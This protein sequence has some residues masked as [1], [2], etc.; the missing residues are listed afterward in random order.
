MKNICITLICSLLIS[1]IASAGPR[2]GS[3]RSAGGK[4]RAGS[5]SIRSA[6]TRNMLSTELS[7]NS[8]TV[9][10]EKDTSTCEDIFY[11]CMDKKTT[12]VVMQNEIIY[13]DYNDMITDIY[14]GMSTPAFKCVYSPELKTI[15]SK[16]YYNRTLSA[17]IGGRSEKI[18]TK[19]IEYYNYLKQNA[20]DVA[21][22]KIPVNFIQN[23]VL[24]IAGIE[25]EPHNMNSEN[26]PDVSYKI[27]TIEPTKL[28]E[29][30]VEY[31][32][33]ESKNEELLG[34]QKL[35]KSLAEKWKEENPSLKK[36]CND[37]EVFLTEKMSKEKSAAEDFI[38]TLK[39]KLTSAIEEYNLKIEADEQ[40][41]ALEEAEAVRDKKNANNTNNTQKT[42]GTTAKGLIKS[43][44]GAGLRF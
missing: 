40:L 19:S 4:R 26:L 43:I 22:K 7:S 33:D 28:F 21:S 18:R 27:T 5:S 17:P 41:K 38:K 9:V 24:T 39:T 12:E 42:L 36:S 1:N 23:E 3:L 32:L 29:A 2:G 8:N 10:E 44:T 16:Y 30:N 34:C 37:Y 20:S 31:C 14:S 11:S 6:S 15:Y 25:I 35:K 13:N